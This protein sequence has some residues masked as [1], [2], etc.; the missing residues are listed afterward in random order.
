MF[1]LNS[2]IGLMIFLQR[3]AAPLAAGPGRIGACSPTRPAGTTAGGGDKA[4]LIVLATVVVFVQLGRCLLFIYQPICARWSGRQACT[5]RR[6][7]LENE[8]AVQ[9]D[10]FLADNAGLPIALMVLPADLSVVLPGRP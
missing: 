5:P 3:P 9:D 2:H 6:K 1:S 10:L 8:A 7:L 4:V